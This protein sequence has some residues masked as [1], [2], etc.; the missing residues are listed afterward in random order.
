MRVVF[1][2]VHVVM[3]VGCGSSHHEKAATGKKKKAE[4]DV[5]LQFSDSQSSGL[6]GL[7]A[8]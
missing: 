3:C 7:R 6:G 8:L 1:S 4:K 5:T 2:D